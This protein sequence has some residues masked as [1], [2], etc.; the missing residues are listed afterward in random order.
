VA[1]VP[2]HTRQLLCRRCADKAAGWLA[3]SPD[4]LLCLV[5]REPGVL[6]DLMLQ[7]GTVLV[8]GRH[9]A[10]CNAAVYGCGR[11][12]FAGGDG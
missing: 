4:G 5:C 12:R 11:E 3:S 10:G 9:C 7:V 1:F 6:E 8:T 2:A